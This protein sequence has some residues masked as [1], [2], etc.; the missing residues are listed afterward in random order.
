MRL[1]TLG[2]LQKIFTTVALSLVFSAVTFAARPDDSAA[3]LSRLVAIQKIEY[4]RKHY[5]RATDLIGLNTAE[6]IAQ[7][8]AI[9]RSIFTADAKIS[10]TEHG[11]VVFTAEGPD[12]WVDVAA[13][14]LSVFA[15]TQHLIGTQLVE[16]KS[17]PDAS[18]RG[19]EAT[20]TSYLQAWHDD[21]DRVLDIFIGTY[22]D[23]LRY[24]PENGW[25]IYAMVLEKVSGEVTAK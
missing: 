4:L 22:H 6:S 12:A 7:G 25:Q 23:Q 18:G 17:L 1:N 19:G 13:Q 16:I 8:R 15:N 3:Q 9:Y 2:I 24:S 14:A 11:K 10:T 5:A 21:P 20:M